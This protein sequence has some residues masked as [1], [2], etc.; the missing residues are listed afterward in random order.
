MNTLARKYEMIF[1]SDDE[2]LDKLAVQKYQ[3]SEEEK[4]T[5]IFKDGSAL[6]FR[7]CVGSI[8]ENY[9]LSADNEKL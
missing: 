3:N 6:I 5:W 1:G 9:E 8:I 2:Y 7:G 4:T